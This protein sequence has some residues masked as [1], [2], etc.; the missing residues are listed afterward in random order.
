MLYKSV[1]KHLKKRIFQVILLTL[2]M[3]MSAFIYVI[4]EYSISALKNPAEDFFET[5]VQEDFNVTV[6]EQ[7][8]PFDLE[9]LDA[10]DIGDSVTLSDLY[11]NNYDTYITLINNRLS[12]FSNTFEDTQ[13]EPRLHKDIYYTYDDEQH[14]MRILKDMDEIKLHL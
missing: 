4:M 12:A 1:F 10:V 11:H 14:L 2:I 7:I 13:L 5:Y 8:L 9:N 6:S 3:I